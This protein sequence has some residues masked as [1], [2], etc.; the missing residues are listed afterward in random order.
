MVS[1]VST[2]IIMSLI[3]GFRVITL[4]KN[5]VTVYPIDLYKYTT[6]YS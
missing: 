3:S 4:L 5:K 1:T 2:Y 6:Y